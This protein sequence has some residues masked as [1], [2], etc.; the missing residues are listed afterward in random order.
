MSSEEDVSWNNLIL[1]PLWI[2]QGV[3][4]A[5]ALFV[6]IT[7]VYLFVFPRLDDRETLGQSLQEAKARYA[8]RLLRLGTLPPLNQL[9]EQVEEKTSYL[10]AYSALPIGVQS[11]IA[12]ARRS[13]C[14]VADVKHLADAE[15]ATFWTQ[16]WQLKLKGNYFQLFEFIQRMGMDKDAVAAVVERLEMEE[17]GGL[18][19]SLIVTQYRLKEE[20]R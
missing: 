6:S 15:N 11:L 8:Q 14:R 10:K 7:G 12:R 9:D 13:E 3:A 20:V 1:A 2:R 16:R 18:V 5:V 4:L 17:E 19:L